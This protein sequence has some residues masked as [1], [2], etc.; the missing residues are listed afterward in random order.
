[1]TPNRREILGVGLAGAAG[2][3]GIAAPQAAAHTGTLPE[4]EWKKLASAPKSKADFRKLAGHFN[5]LRK[6]AEEEARY[7]QEL[8]QAYRHKGIAGFTESQA[9]DAARA[10]EHVAEHARDTAE[11]LEHLVETYDGLGENF[12]G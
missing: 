3:L 9:H 12:K 6:G 10:L 1:M 7:Y 11:A 8:A 2:L 4:A 5:A